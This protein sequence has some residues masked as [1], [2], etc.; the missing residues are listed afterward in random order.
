VVTTPDQ[1]K[2]SVADLRGWLN[3]LSNA[4]PVDVRRAV[5]QDTVAIELLSG[6]RLLLEPLMEVSLG[7]FEGDSLSMRHAD[8]LK[9]SIAE[10][11]RLA[12]R[13]AERLTRTE[14]RTV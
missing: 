9:T 8:L 10:L 4:Q 7:Q 13:A 12:S 6:V 2:A 3:H 11:A 1:I 5:V 14:A